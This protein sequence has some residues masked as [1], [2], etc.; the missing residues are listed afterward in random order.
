MA[1][2]ERREG[3]RGVSYR[4][5][6]SCGMDSLGHQIMRRTTWRPEPGMTAR[7]VEKALARAAAD[8]EREIEQG[9]ALDNRQTFSGY[10]KYV[11][12]MKE[13][14]G[15]KR[16]TLERYE[17]LLERINQAIGHMKLADIRP[18]HLNSLYQNLREEGIRKDGGHAIMRTDLAAWLKVHKT[19]KT[20]LAKKAG[21]AAST[22]AAA[23]KGQSIQRS[24][25]EAIA[26]AMN[27]GLE[28][29][30]DVSVKSAPL[31]P[32][33]ILE[34]HRLISTI[35]GL[36]EKEM[37]VPY[38]AAAKA[39]PPKV[40]RK[41]PNYFQ[42]EDIAAILDALEREPLKWQAI[43]HLLIVTGCRRGE[44]MG[45]KWDKVDL[46]RQRITIDRA[47]LVGKD[48]TAYEDTTKTGDTRYLNIPAETAQLLK[49]HRR[50]QAIMRLQNGDRW[51]ETGYVFT[52][53]DGRPMNPDS[54]TGWL[55]DFS[56]RNGL[57]HIN[58]HA[59]RHTAASVLIAA[60]TDVVTVSKQ[61]GH[62]SV[63]TTE[64][65]YSHMI[66]EAKAQ[67]AECIADVLLRRR[68]P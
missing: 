7:Q 58:P 8:F 46:D 57:P 53:D 35:L 34:H 27:G 67:A 47:L 30:F 23:G 31:S 10:A 40:D 38:N 9:Y 32:K 17:E 13:Q 43:T 5:S 22:L 15:A 26:R 54:V 50:E 18:Q 24:T 63:S 6:V 61:L 45:L 25:A 62:S 68:S 65:F 12:V 60:G 36:A 4:I 49:E 55:S 19:S 33:T 64:S 3:K 51:Q 16:R 42:P 2:I 44:I 59:F 21:C 41:E 66:E 39:T 11:L 29:I 14:A 37:L 28:D 52:R 48:G 20:A 56:K 1:W